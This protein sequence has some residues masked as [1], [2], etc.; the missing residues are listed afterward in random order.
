MGGVSPQIVRDWIVRFNAH[1]AA[2]LI[3]PT[4]LCGQLSARPRHHAQDEQAISDFKKASR[5]RSYDDILGI[6]CEASDV[7][8]RPA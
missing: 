5:V 8:S 2:G 3:K 4:A 6:C 7:R 1:G